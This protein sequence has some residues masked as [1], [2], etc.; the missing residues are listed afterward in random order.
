MMVLEESRVEADIKRL[1]ASLAQTLLEED[2]L[3]TADLL[4][5]GFILRMPDGERIAKEE[6]IGLIASRQI[7]F[8][9]LSLEMGSIH[10]YDGQ[11]AFLSGHC[12]GS[13]VFRNQ[14]M[15]GGFAFTAL[16]VCRR[17]IWQ[18]V[19]IHRLEGSEGSVLGATSQ[20]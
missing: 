15:S 17:G 2:A 16:C 6:L 19:A 3:A 9:S 8:D 20:Q 4:D 7:R 5:E 14:R 1:G 11:V 18:I 12:S 13:R 10:V